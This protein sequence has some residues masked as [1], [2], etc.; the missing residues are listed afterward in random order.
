MRFSLL[1]AGI[2]TIWADAALAQGIAFGGKRCRAEITGVQII[3]FRYLGARQM[4]TRY[5]HL[6]W[7]FSEIV[8]LH[9]ARS[10]PTWQAR[11]RQPLRPFRPRKSRLVHASKPAPLIQIKAHTAQIVDGRIGSARHQLP[12]TNSVCRKHTMI[13]P[14]PIVQ[15]RVALLP[16]AAF[17]RLATE[18]RLAHV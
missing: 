5:D 9:E 3:P 14:K 17:R 8:L 7:R 12:Q 13:A 15:S 1:L 2:L 16:K 4:E 11:L 18:R 6:L 10:R